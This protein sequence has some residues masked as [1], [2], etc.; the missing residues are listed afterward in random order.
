MGLQ[1]LLEEIGITPEQTCIIYEDNDGS[2]RL[3][4][5]G[6]GPKEGA[7]L[8]NQKKHHYVQ[9]LCRNNK[10][11]IVQVASGNQPADLLT[12]GSYTC[13][14]HLHLRTKLGIVSHACNA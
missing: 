10:L 4:M 9:E 1:N 11:R 3:A 13:K 5:R 6:H 7:P 14:M 2:G 8:A 12:K